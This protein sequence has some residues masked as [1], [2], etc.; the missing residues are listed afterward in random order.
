MSIIGWS[1]H[2]CGYMYVVYVVYVTFTCMSAFQDVLLTTK[3]MHV[4]SSNISAKTDVSMAVFS[5][6]H[7]K[8]HC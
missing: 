3:N 1:L 6:H 2:M 7:S 8:S 4:Y 5:S